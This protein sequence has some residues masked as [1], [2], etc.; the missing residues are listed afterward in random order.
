MNFVRS[1]EEESYLFNSGSTEFLNNLTKLLK[2]GDVVQWY[3]MSFLQFTLNISYCR[4]ILIN[5]GSNL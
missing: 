3:M 1:R 4:K 2:Y 5:I